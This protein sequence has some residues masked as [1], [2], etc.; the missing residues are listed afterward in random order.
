MNIGIAFKIFLY[1]RS[2]LAAADAKL[3]GKTEVTD[4]VNNAE[5]D[6]LRVRP[7]F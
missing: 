5:I 3:I 7:L 6:S 1:I 4:S 2:R